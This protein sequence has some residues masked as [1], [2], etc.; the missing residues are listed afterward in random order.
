MGE[1]RNRRKGR[2]MRLENEDGKK[3]EKNCDKT[4]TKKRIKNTNVEK[5]EAWEI[6][7]KTWK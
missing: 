6:Q 7:K 2:K 3:E 4:E 1:E 5:R